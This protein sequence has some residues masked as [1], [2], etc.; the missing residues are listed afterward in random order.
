MRPQ[1]TAETGRV[2]RWATGRP[3]QRMAWCLVLLLPCSAAVG[4][5]LGS[6]EWFEKEWKAASKWHVPSFTLFEFDRTDHRYATLA[7][8]QSLAAL[9]EGKPEH[10][11]RFEYEQKMTALKNPESTARTRIWFGRDGFRRSSDGQ[12]TG[13]VPYYSDDVVRKKITWS[14]NNRILPDPSIP[15]LRIINTRE[16]PSGQDYDSKLASAESYAKKMVLGGLGDTMAFT[17]RVVSS[18]ID[19][20]GRWRAT[21]E[22]MDGK[23][24]RDYTGTV[25]AENGTILVEDSVVRQA[26]DLEHLVGYR[27]VYSEWSYSEYFKRPI[28][29][30]VVGF[31][32]GSRP[33]LT[34]NLDRFSRFDPS[35]FA[36]LTRIPSDDVPDLVRGSPASYVRN[37]ARLGIQQMTTVSADG[38]TE[39]RNLMPPD[40]EKS[41]WRW[42]ILGFLIVSIV[43]GVIWVIHRR[44]Q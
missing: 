2:A 6:L 25:D 31:R 21:V 7:E 29:H 20:Q 23:L 3:V 37:D 26:E 14:L 43:F 5:E 10:P 30:K 11:S 13:E 41:S 28:A 44:T 17:H 1:Q 33:F 4:Q 36:D 38:S 34:L 19:A 32:G 8:V 40:V 42:R 16:A 27:W 35:T 22:T 12:L 24:I 18:H 9:I 39:T 15:H